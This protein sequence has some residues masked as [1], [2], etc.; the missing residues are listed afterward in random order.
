[1]FIFAK[2]IGDAKVSYNIQTK[3][4]NRKIFR[5]LGPEKKRQLERKRRK[6]FESRSCGLQLTYKRQS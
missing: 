1:M 5:N 6:L 2:G 3:Y 4:L